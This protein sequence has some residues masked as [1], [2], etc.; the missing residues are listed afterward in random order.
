M[1]LEDTVVPEGEHQAGDEQR[2]DGQHAAA[3]AASQR[4][5]HNEHVVA[6][7]S[8]TQRRAR[9]WGAWAMSVG[10][11]A[12][13]RERS[14]ALVRRGGAVLAQL[15]QDGCAALSRQFGE[16]VGGGEAAR[17]GAGVK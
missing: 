9:T 8:F 2:H 11:V 4:H 17:G 1:V 12:V 6:R 15:E 10:A 5:L 14:S 7:K 3:L 13:A 16:S